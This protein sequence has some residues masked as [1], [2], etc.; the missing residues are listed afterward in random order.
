MGK[1]ANTLYIGGMC[2]MCIGLS[3]HL[4]RA[5]IDTITE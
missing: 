4:I 5:V 1:V 3:I 2:S